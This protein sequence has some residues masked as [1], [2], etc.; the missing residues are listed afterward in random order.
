MPWGYDKLI[1]IG[2]METL[3]QSVSKEETPPDEMKEVMKKL[4]TRAH[5]KVP[6]SFRGVLSYGGMT[7][8]FS[9]KDELAKHTEVW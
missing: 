9:M 3:Q 5:P 2:G 1:D 8:S 4:Y 6:G 7:K